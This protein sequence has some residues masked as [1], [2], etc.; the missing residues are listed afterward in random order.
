M[1]L[2]VTQ[3]DKTI[4]FKK[5][6]EVLK[7]PRAQLELAKMSILEDFTGFSVGAVPPFAMPKNVPVIFDLPIKEIGTAWC[8]TGDPS[9]SLKVSIGTLER[10]AS[11]SYCEI[12]KLSRQAPLAP[13]GAG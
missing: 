4:S 13:Q 7:L 5:V 8:G 2:L 12:S 11:A 1:W 10:M 3:A 6:A 9:Q